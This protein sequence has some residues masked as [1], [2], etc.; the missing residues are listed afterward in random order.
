VDTMSSTSINCKV[1]SKCITFFCW[2]TL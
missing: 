2:L 1:T